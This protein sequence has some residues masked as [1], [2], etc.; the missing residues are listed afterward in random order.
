MKHFNTETQLQL[1]EKLSNP[2]KFI[3][4]YNLIVD[5]LNQLQDDKV[6]GVLSS[7][8]KDFDISSLIDLKLE[9]NEPQFKFIA[10]NFVYPDNKILESQIAVI[11]NNYG[12]SIGY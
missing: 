3:D 10:K 5:D 8:Y 4:T 9:N 11:T 7:Y 2:K 12:L 1:V 6:N